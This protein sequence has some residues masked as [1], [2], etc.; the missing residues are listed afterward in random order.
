MSKLLSR[1][2]GVDEWVTTLADYDAV[3]NII[4]DI[5]SVSSSCAAEDF[6]SD[7]FGINWEQQ[8]RFELVS[9]TN[10]FKSYIWVVKVLLHFTLS[11]TTYE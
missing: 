6:S 8:S 5:P 9:S 1:N 10:E 7:A 2:L 3:S 4:D 11:C